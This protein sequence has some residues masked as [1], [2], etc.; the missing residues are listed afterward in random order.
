[1][2]IR[3][4]P[5]GGFNKKGAFIEY[6]GEEPTGN[7]L[8]YERCG[9]LTIELVCDQL[10]IHT[11]LDIVNKSEGTSIT[12]LAVRKYIT[13]IC[14][15]QPAMWSQFSL[16]F[17]GQ[18]REHS[19]INLS[20][21]AGKEGDIAMFSGFYFEGDQDVQS[22][23]RFSLELVLSSAR[24][25]ALL[26][27]L[28]KASTS[29]FV[30]V[31]VDKFAGFYATWSPMIS[32][33]RVI[34]FLNEKHDV[35][36]LGDIPEDFWGSGSEMEERLLSWNSPPVSLAAV[37]PLG[38]PV[39]IDDPKIEFSESSEVLPDIEVNRGAHERT[40]TIANLTKQV[41]STGLWLSFCVVLLV[42][43]VLGS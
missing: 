24:F 22:R 9:F 4:I 18:K 23:D 10:K 16:S 6:E 2:K 33:G 39:A 30:K 7:E 5:K 15:I 36:N 8:E 14:S 3:F 20:L 38:S 21:H 17:L 12:D 28:S 40:D 37:R 41:R 43:A 11:A 32:D 31:D 25:E 27:E 13:G 1:M 42:L 26:L 19:S 35:E 29:I 34:K